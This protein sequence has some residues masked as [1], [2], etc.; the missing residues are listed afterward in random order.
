MKRWAV[1]ITLAYALLWLALA[2]P[3]TWLCV[4]FDW[5]HL[6]DGGG[7]VDFY[8]L[9]SGWFLWFLFAVV[10]LCQIALLLVPIQAEKERFKARRGIIWPALAITFLSANLL[11][12]GG[13][14]LAVL[15]VDF[16]TIFTPVEL[17]ADSFESVME[18][19]L[20]YR[21]TGLPLTLD[22]M[23]YIFGGTLVFIGIFWL[24]WGWVFYH[25]YMR[26]QSEGMVRLWFNRLWRGSV[27]ELLVALPTHILMRS[28][29]DC[30][31]PMV[32]FM[33]IVTGLSVMLLCFGPGVLF[34]YLER[35]RRLRA[36]Q[37]NIEHPT[38]NIEHRQSGG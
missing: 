38:P 28:K 8:E 11:F 9:F 4:D 37:G 19:G 6:S 29:E 2:Y 22:S 16:D 10:V 25:Y 26:A 1:I 20:F 3:V 5:W 12:W 13:S 32:S 31:A 27:L 21:L 34:L 33:G 23:W 18:N 7:D 35:A 15:A 24:I 36:K 17:V 30:C 14:S